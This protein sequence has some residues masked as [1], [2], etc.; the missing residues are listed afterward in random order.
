MAVSVSNCFS[1]VLLGSYLI[2]SKK[3]EHTWNGFSFETFHYILTNVKLALPSAAMVC[4]EYWA[5]EILVFLAGI[6]PN[7]KITTSLIAICVN[8][9][10]IA[11]MLTYGLSAAASTRVSNEL[12][13]GNPNRAKGAMAVTL[14]LSV[15]LALI[16]VLALAFGHNVWAALFSDSHAIIKEFA[17]MAPFLAV[18]I[19][20]DSI[21]GVLSGVARG[22]GWQHLA[23]YGNL[24][25]FY[26]IGM[27][28]ACLVGFKLKLYVQGLWIGLIC[29]LSCQTATLLLIAMKAKWTQKISMRDEDNPFVA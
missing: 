2:F 11:Y 10:S 21:Q 12:G 19:T 27:P 20:F 4:L 17:S 7:S 26:F 15:S 14:K 16:V 24:A 13:A 22:C 28:I 8:T 29:G 18:S 23:V 3:F 5:F 1:V 9:E 6:M 25:T